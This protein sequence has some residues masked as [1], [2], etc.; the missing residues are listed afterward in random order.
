MVASKIKWIKEDFGCAE[1]IPHKA[2]YG[3]EKD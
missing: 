3:F 2:S 1:R